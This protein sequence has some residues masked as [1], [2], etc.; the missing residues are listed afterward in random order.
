MRGALGLSVKTKKTAY[1]AWKLLV[2]FNVE[3][4]GVVQRAVGM[5]FLSSRGGFICYF[6]TKEHFRRKLTA[7]FG[8]TDCS[9]RYTTDCPSR[10]T[11]DCSSRH[12]TDCPS[13]HVIDCPSRHA[14]DRQFTPPT[15]RHAMSLTVTPRH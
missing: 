15:I 2:L 1:R 3:A 8:R 9:S 11:T 4:V 14:T 6:S 7:P 5:P 12:A 13:R 10:F